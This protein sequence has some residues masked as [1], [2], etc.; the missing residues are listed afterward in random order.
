VRTESNLQITL[1]NEID[2]TSQIESTVMGCLGSMIP[3]G[4]KYKN[5]FRHIHRFLIGVD[6]IMGPKM[7]WHCA[8]LEQTL[9]VPV[10]VGR[11]LHHCSLLGVFQESLQLYSGTC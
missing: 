5:V 7:R 6:L 9:G 3:K 4:V 2:V 1:M 11:S 10:L 8:T